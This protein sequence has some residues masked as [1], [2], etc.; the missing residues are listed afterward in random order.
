MFKK[1][2][3]KLGGEQRSLIF[4]T[5]RT[6]EAIARGFRKNHLAYD[7]CH[8]K[9]HWAIST[10]QYFY[11]EPKSCLPKGGIY[12]S[13]KKMATLTWNQTVASSISRICCNPAQLVLKSML[14]T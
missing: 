4:A 1:K 5:P 2:K 9:G 13:F 14:S 6:A 3:K 12:V 10:N 7:R 11:C 8:R